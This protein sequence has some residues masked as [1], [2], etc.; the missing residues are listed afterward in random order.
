MISLGAMLFP[1]EQSEAN[2]SIQ[3]YCARFKTNAAPAI[4]VQGDNLYS[5]QDASVQSGSN[6]RLRDGKSCLYSVIPKHKF[7]G[8]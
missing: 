7:H 8:K 6:M 4:R 2:K 3:E 5:Y 1:Y